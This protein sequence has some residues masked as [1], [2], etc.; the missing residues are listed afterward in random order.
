M[1]C[2]LFNHSLS[3]YIYKQDFII[4]P[5]DAKILRVSQCTTG[6]VVL[7]KFK[8]NG[9]KYFY[10]L[11]EPKEDK[12]EEY[13]KKVSDY[14]NNDTNIARFIIFYNLCIELSGRDHVSCCQNTNYLIKFPIKVNEFIDNPTSAVSALSDT[15]LGE[16]GNQRIPQSYMGTF[17][18]LLLLLLFPSPSLPPSLLANLLQGS[19]PDNAT[20]QQLLELLA[21]SGNRQMEI[22]Q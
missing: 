16:L 15:G 21:M 18:S 4:F 11:Q 19:L 7:L 10:W 5:G 13:I 14:D 1:H 3:M 9:R 17:T 20:Q 2:M 22:L 12:D 6:R 8:D